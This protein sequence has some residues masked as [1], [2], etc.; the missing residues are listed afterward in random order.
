M[1]ENK[2][3]SNNCQNNYDSEMKI[4]LEYCYQTNISVVKHDDDAFNSRHK[5]MVKWWLL[6]YW[7]YCDVSYLIRCHNLSDFSILRKIYLCQF[8]IDTI[9]ICLI[10]SINIYRI[11]IKLWIDE[12]KNIYFA[13][14]VNLVSKFQRKYIRCTGKHRLFHSI[15]FLFP[16]LEI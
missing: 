15:I 5:I 8:C 14:F 12:I 1:R 11:Y 7:K 4:M 16:P 6:I 3:C 13:T 10:Y 2:W 9:A